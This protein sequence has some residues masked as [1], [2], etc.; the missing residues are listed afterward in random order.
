MTGTICH[1]EVAGNA[2]GCTSFVL[3]NGDY[4]VLGANYDWHLGVGLIMVNKRGLKKRAIVNQNTKGEPISWVSKY[5]SVTFNQYGRE[6]PVCGMNEAGLIANG[7]LLD[8]SNYPA[9]DT[10]PYI[11]KG[12]WKQYVL[13]N[14][15]SVAEVVA[16]PSP[17]RVLPPVKSPGLHYIICDQTGDCAIIEYIN[18]NR[19]VFTHESLPIKVITNRSY[20]E[21]VE[22]YVNDVPF[23]TDPNRALERFIIAAEAIK[24]YR[25]KAT[26]PPIMSALAILKKV[27]QGSRTKWSI[28]YDLK[29][30]RIYYRTRSQNDRKWIDL[31]SLDFS[32]NSKTKVLDV[33][34]AASGDI[35]KRF[36]EYS[37][38][39]NFNLIRNAF[40]NT[41]FLKD[42]SSKKLIKLSEYP[43]SF[44]CEK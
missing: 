9:P 26:Q 19:V 22:T 12:Q 27:D 13:D 1:L 4:N 36:Q 11:G 15:K 44:E 3:E 6:L 10:R 14:Y 32:C 7:L 38:K 40:S 35:A 41:H 39:I 5:G 20:S 2:F 24:K 42:I 25:T 16:Q 18:G 21:C 17:V 28:V 37:R 8:R 31:N 33:N 23:F 29:K 43:E 30:M 34:L